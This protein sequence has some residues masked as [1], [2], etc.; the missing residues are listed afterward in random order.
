MACPNFGLAPN[1]GFFAA[2]FFVGMG[3]ATSYETKG[4][5]LLVDASYDAALSTSGGRPHL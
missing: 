4:R 5:F 3:K 1:F 2:F